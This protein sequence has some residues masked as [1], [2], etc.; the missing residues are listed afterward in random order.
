MIRDDPTTI[1]AGLGHGPILES[2]ARTSQKPVK[3]PPAV[4]LLKTK[5][6]DLRGFL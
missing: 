4:S 1:A 3:R 2:P 6:P 5:S